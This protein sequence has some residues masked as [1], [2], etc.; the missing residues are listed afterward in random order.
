L[1]SRDADDCG[2]EF[3]PAVC[4]KTQ[5]TCKNL[6]FCLGCKTSRL[7]FYAVDA[8]FIFSDYSHEMLVDI[9]WQD[10]YLS[11]KLVAVS[12]LL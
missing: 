11:C 1:E 5:L 7:F 9:H 10:K 12:V 6:A 8:H 2:K 3:F 4:L